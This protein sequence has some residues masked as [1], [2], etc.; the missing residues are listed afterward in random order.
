[1][2]TRAI[3]TRSWSAN[4]FALLTVVSLLFPGIV[5]PVAPVL[6][7]EAVSPAAVQESL[8][9]VKP[10]PAPARP[11]AAC[12]TD[13][14]F[15]E[16]IE[17]SSSNKAI[18]IYNGTGAVVDLSAYRVNLYTNGSST[19]NSNSTNLSGSLAAGD[20]YV[21]IN[22]SATLA[23]IKAQADMTSTVINYN[24]NDALVLLHNGVVIDSIG[25]VGEDPGTNGWGTDP[26]NTTDNTLVRKATITAGDIITDDTYDP[27]V[28][29]SG[30][31]VDTTSYLGSHTMT[32]GATAPKVSSTSPVSE[33]TGV[34]LATT[35]RVV[36]DQVISGTTVTTDTF[37]LV[38][39]SGAIE[40]SVGYD[41]ASHSATFTPTAALT[42]STRYTASATSGI[43]NSA[44]ALTAYSWSFTTLDPDV[45]APQVSGTSPSTGAAGVALTANV[46]ATFNEAVTGVDGT[47]FTLEG[48][49]GAVAGTVIYTAATRTATFIPSAPFAGLTVYT[50]T[51][52][53]GIVD[54]SSNPLATYTWT[55]T[56]APS[57][58]TPP[59]VTSNY[60]MAGA[61]GISVLA[62]ITATFDEA[63]NGVSAS[64]FL[65]E[66]PTGAVAGAVSYNSGTR[67]ATFDPGVTLGGLTLYTVTL[68]SAITDLVG[69]PLAT[70]TWTFTTEA[71]DV[72]PPTVTSNYPTDGATAVPATDNITATFDEAVS[73]VSASSFILTG[74]AGAVTGTVSYNSGTRTATFNPNLTLQG[75]TRYT[76][77]LTNGIVDALNNAL[78]TYTWSFTTDVVLGYTPIATARAAG[79]GWTGSVRGYVSVLPGAYRGNAFVIQDATGGLYIYT[80]AA[81]P[82]AMSLGDMVQ[83]TGTLKLYNGLL[84]MDPTTAMKNLSPNIPPQIV[85]ATPVSTS[86][87]IVTGTQGLLVQI[88]GTATWT[89][90]F[91][92]PGAVDWSMTLNDGS[93]PVTVFVDKDTAINMGSF[94]SPTQFIVTG[95]SG[96]YNTPQVMP[97]TQSD[98]VEIDVRAPQVTGTFPTTGATGANPYRAVEASFNEALLAGT[99]NAASFTLTGPAGAVAG[100][101]SYVADS[102]K[103]VFTP[104]SALAAMTT[105]TATVGTGVTDLAGNALAAPVSWSFTTGN[106]DVQAPSITG[107]FPASGATAVAIDTG[108]VVTFSEELNPASLTGNIFVEGAFGTVPARM[109]YDAATYRVSLTPSAPLLPLTRY[110]VTVRGAVADWA[111]LT[112][113]T[114]SV[115]A[116]TTATEPPMQ[117]YRG[118][119]HNHTSYS[120][121]SGTPEQAL[122][123][124]KSAGMDFMA[125]SDH[126]YAIDDTEWTATQSAVDAA[127]NSSFVGLRGFEYTQ[128]A[129]GH[130]NVY[131]TTRHAVRTNTTA[132]CTSCDYTPNLEA[133]V[134]V[135]GFYQWLAVTGTMALDGAGTVMQFNHPGWINFN[136]WAFHNEVS[137]T[138]RMEEVG[139]GY[140][141]SY[142]FSEDEY[143]RSLDY[144]WKVGAS[145]NADT[146][147]TYWGINTD[148]RTGVWM[149]GLTRANLL[150]ALR[151]RRTFAT[152]DKNYSLRLKANGVWMGSE[153]ANTGS[154]SFDIYGYDPDGE[155][156]TLVQLVTDQGKVVT[157]TSA[158]T[159]TFTWMP[160][161]TVTTGV[162]YFYVKVTQT[163]GDRI[164]SS[165]VWTMGVE[166]ISITDVVIQPT[167]PTIHNPSLLTARVT[168]RVD[169]TR[170]VTVTMLVNGVALPGSVA[171]NVP[172]FS[173]AYANFTWQPTVTGTATVLAQ[174]TGAPAGDNPDDNQDQLVLDVTD[175][176]LPLILIDAGHGNINAPGREMRMFIADLS[177]HHYNV[178]K[179]LDALTAADLNTA[180][181][182]LLIITAPEFAYT[183]AEL[184]AIADYVAGG[185][186]IWLCG[187]A[188]YPGKVAWASSVADRLNAIVDK[189]ETRSGTPINMR[190]NDDEVIDADDNNGYVFG[191]LWGSFPSTNTTS[192]GLNVNSLASWSLSSLRGRTVADPL[193]ASTPGVTIVVQGDLDEGYGPSPWRNPNHTTSVDSD[194]Q[195]DAYVYNPTWVYPATQPAGA[196][197]VPMGAVSQ[198]PNGGGRIMLYGDS[199]DAFGT[200][201]YTAGDGKQNELFNLEAVMWL[202]GQPLQK[203]T[204]AQARADAELDNTPEN[205][206][207][208]VWVEGKITAA[209]G[210]FFNV[211]YIDDGTG[212]ITVH[213]PAG[214]I[215]AAQYARGATVRVV[216]T[217]GIYEGDTEIEFFE[218]EQV[219]VITPT[220]GIEPLPMPLTT[221]SATLEVNQ[222]R[223]AVITGTVMTKT[224]V[225]DLWINDGSGPM[226]LFL[227]GY[228]GDW[229]DITL[230]SRIVVS[231]MVSEDGGGARIRVRNHKAHVGIP[232]DVT[233]LNAGTQIYL[234]L[235]MRKAQP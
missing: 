150:E 77:T 183:D 164:V 232:E 118:D 207:K 17:G 57:D 195:T 159:G 131:N 44:G 92:T 210:E 169:T 212:G 86:A 30:F 209:F 94:V 39:P 68:T 137:N 101:V 168:N 95:F 112:L 216:G 19:P 179:N 52:S 59:T 157:Q 49:S 222:G 66:G 151:A 223:L 155:G 64:S 91:T 124:G 33:A 225:S 105:Y 14:F 29:W 132:T 60:P 76:A 9:A 115:W 114:D 135:Q 153:L 73:G 51:L 83:V 176:H 122:A 99:V 173:D 20:V 214:D 1:M 56:T 36:F 184:N 201:A 192:I 43:T 22:G 18:E 78:V 89:R 65:L 126:S 158:V 154:I 208:L 103:A 227:D 119:I 215:D 200:F 217:V 102:R 111:G 140:G 204:I 10:T 230:K 37:T 213:A 3:G 139:N 67:T 171:V 229:N 48:P 219:Q 149:P 231:G 191:V 165:P 2:N 202:L 58:V 98:I 50:A 7:A 79:V 148:H 46:T 234:P 31:A 220:D 70:Y 63:V 34:A 196:V 180:T 47:S 12:P 203:S 109:V 211:L 61:T 26:T 23:D 147:S 143:I 25:K 134:T 152:E 197:P 88:R 62:N 110:T 28:E 35:V 45:T 13:L 71:L 145:N 27:A 189:I 141:T 194:N 198:L 161:I 90:V 69:N 128:G 130:I 21:I 8:P 182:K 172:P 156:V 55:F 32:C 108:V 188:D 199:N 174:F 190:L 40:G 142:V 187:T 233:V 24:G 205:L 84:E 224:G 175:A 235:V 120:D 97:R 206:D 85:A 162:H 228:N 127:T 93:G 166:D 226:R 38:G 104:N 53:S 54:L 186:S 4:L 160:Q 74:P 5:A 113:G 218:A 81:T 138:A 123:A 82:P 193:T 41:D 117:A 100:T 107:R 133:G 167:I 177:D 116:F 72:T 221:Y 16:Y 185:G 129:E 121:G 136:D 11:M 181:V 163:D 146:H 125:I 178:L 6:G 170:T 42:Y 144:G 15:S 106:T 75:L 87:S 80:G 96:A